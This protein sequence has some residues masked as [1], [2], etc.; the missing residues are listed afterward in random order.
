MPIV[1]QVQGERSGPVVVCDFCGR[2]IDDVRAG[3]CQWIMGNDAADPGAAIYF[4]HKKCCHPF[5]EANKH[6]EG[7]DAD[8]RHRMWGAIDLD[9]FLFYLE[10]RTK[11]DR[12]E[13][14]K[15]P[16]FC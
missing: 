12:E 7:K 4:T 3:N 8:G 2:T 6:H 11:F 1:M 15:R 5:E 9:Q 14:K 13:A 10:N 16:H